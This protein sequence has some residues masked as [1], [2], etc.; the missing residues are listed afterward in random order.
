MILLNIKRRETMT[1]MVYAI[2]IKIVVK[3]NQLRN[4]N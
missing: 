4:L 2:I 1:S 3:K